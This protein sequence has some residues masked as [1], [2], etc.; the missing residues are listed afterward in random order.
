VDVQLSDE[1]VQQLRVL[2]KSALGDLSMEIAD[3]DSPEYRRDLEDRRSVLRNVQ[4][5]LGS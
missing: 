4:E 5:V 1:E 3:T 2:L